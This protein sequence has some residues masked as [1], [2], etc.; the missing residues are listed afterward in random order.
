MTLY[1]SRT[2]PNGFFITGTDTGVGKT[3][4]ACAMLHAFART[5][6]RVAGMKPVAAG[7]AQSVEGLVNDDVAQL[8][9]ASNVQA[10]LAL[11]N[12]YCFAPAIAPHIAAAQSGV[13]IDLNHI[14]QA[15][16]QLAAAAD[17]VVVEG[18]GGFC[19]PLNDD[20]DTA[21]LARHLGLPVILVVG[22]RLGCINHA[23]LTAQAIRARGLRLAGWIA[24]R[25]DPDMPVAGEN[26]AALA[27]RLAAPLLG[28]IE[29]T[30]APDPRHVA[31][32]LDLSKFA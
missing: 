12:P 30:V 26:V 27:E 23:L 13:T 16:A 2:A 4:I 19:V 8:R 10:A 31:G 3:L 28:E 9:A 15:Y 1:A 24:N 14:A 6:R 17:T 11:I 25:I 32:L 5:G 18:V 20:E 29:F 7:A 22:V 21:D